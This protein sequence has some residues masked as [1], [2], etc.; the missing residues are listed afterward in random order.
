MCLARVPAE[1]EQDKDVG[2]ESSQQNRSENCLFFSNE[3]CIVL[4]PSWSSRYLGGLNSHLVSVNSEFCGGERRKA[5]R[6]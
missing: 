3:Y 6:V 4:K 1:A 5:G 2:R